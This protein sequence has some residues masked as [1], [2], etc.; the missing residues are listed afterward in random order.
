MWMWLRAPQR[1]PAAPA[2]LNQMAAA[3]AAAPMDARLGGQ[4][5]LS[6]R[7]MR[8]RVEFSMANLVRPPL[9]AMRPMARERCSPFSVFTGHACARAAAR[10]PARPG[11]HKLPPAA[12]S[13]ARSRTAPGTR[14]RG[15]RTVLDLEAVNVQV[16]HAQQRHCVLDRFR[17]ARAYRT[18]P[19]P[20]QASA[21]A[22]RER[23]GSVHG[24]SRTSTSNPIMKARTKSAAFCNAPASSVNSEV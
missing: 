12:A 20:E 6:A 7:T 9:P 14:D 19:A 2:P 5:H 8:V 13:L 17:G 24:D 23:R 21:P 11:V 3:A 4:A 15:V 16:V 1:D 18:T 10:P 22:M